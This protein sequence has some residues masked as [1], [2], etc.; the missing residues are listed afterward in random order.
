MNFK[1]ENKIDNIENQEI[2]IR[3][4]YGIATF[5]DNKVI[6]LKDFSDNSEIIEDNTVSN[7]IYF[8]KLISFSNKQYISYIT[9]SGIRR[10]SLIKDNG[11]NKA[12]IKLLDKD[13]YK[14]KIFY[15]L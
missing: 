2:K 12:I 6:V 14:W 8:D 15:I 13:E 5:I 4:T 9:L 3:V 1:S 10:Y 11:N 7:N